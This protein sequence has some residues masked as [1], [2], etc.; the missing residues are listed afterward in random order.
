MDPELE[1]RRSCGRWL[2][3]DEVEPRRTMRFVTSS[4]TGVGLEVWERK[5]AAAAALERFA[6]EAWFLT[7]A[8]EAASDAEALGGGADRWG[9]IADG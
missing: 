9:C 8:V 7:K 5:A 6:S 2:P 4:P 3:W 1:W